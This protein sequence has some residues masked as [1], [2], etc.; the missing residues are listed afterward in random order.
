ML[1][2]RVF[3]FFLLIRP[4]PTSTL[5][6]YTTLFRSVERG[7][8]VRL[9]KSA[10]PAVEL[11]RAGEGDLAVIQRREGGRAGGAQ[12]GAVGCP[13]LHGT[14][15]RAATVRVERHGWISG[16]RAPP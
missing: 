8:P 14:A 4:P 11:K 1:P 13:E 12:L 15:C 6:P 10:R 5:F 16:D 7:A 3:F 2:T 9:R